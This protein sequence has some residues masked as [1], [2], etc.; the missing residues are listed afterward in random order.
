MEE[1]LEECPICRGAGIISHEGGKVMGMEQILKFHGISREECI[2]FGDG[3]ND[4]EML[5]FAGIGIA[6]GNADPEVKESADYVTADVDE[7]GVLKALR[8]YKLIG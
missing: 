1:M 7:G 4:I 6:M 3:E 5:Q 8:H 2:A